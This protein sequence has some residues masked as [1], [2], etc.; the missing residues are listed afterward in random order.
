MGVSFGFEWFKA[1][2]SFYDIRVFAWMDCL[3]IF[4]FTPRVQS[5]KRF[6]LTFAVLFL[7]GFVFGQEEKKEKPMSPEEE[8]K[9]IQKEIESFGWTRS[10]KGRLGSE[11]QIEIPKGYRFT[12]KSGTKKMLEFTGNISGDNELGVIAP[13]DLNWWV[14]FEFD[15]VG[16]VKDSD[17]DKLD[18][19]AIL[20]QLREGQ[21]AANE[22]RQKQG[23]RKLYLDGWAMPPR[24]NEQSHNLEWAIKVRNEEGGTSIN[25]LTKLLG[26]KGVMHVTLL[27]NPEELKATLPEYQKMIEQFSYMSGQSYAEYRQGDKVA[28]Y[29]LAGLIT[30]GAGV[31]LLKS[32]WLA[33]LGVIFAKGA[34]V[35]VVG[36]IVLLGF[37]K[38]IFM[39]LFG[40]QSSET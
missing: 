37:F 5:M 8:Q 24:Y 1:K 34:K 18:A 27:V 32:G 25:Y 19:D 20:K 4:V 6:V 13:E 22:A 7:G 12:G 31:A 21:E 36:V 35:I 28:Q 40:R 11:A 17:K 38:K 10:G 26:R 15:D 9:A 23:L 29:T 30:A 14:L 33:K 3:G 39:R 2:Y 16:Y